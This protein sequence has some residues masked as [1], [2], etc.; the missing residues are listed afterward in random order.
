MAAVFKIER[1]SDWSVEAEFNDE[2][3]ADISGVGSTVTATIRSKFFGQT[4]LSVG[5]TWVGDGSD[6]KLRLT[7]TDAQTALVPLG[8]IG[9]LVVSVDRSSEN[10]VYVLG[11]IEGI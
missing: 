10:K 7:L 2:T 1:G 5:Y 6:G 8:R 9:E 11:D 3:G 4:L